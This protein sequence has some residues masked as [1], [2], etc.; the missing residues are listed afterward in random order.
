VGGPHDE[1]L[2]FLRCWHWG[3][4]TDPYQQGDTIYCCIIT[5]YNLSYICNKS[6]IPSALLRK[7]LLLQTKCLKI[8]WMIMKV[9]WRLYLTPYV[10][11]LMSLTSTLAHLPLPER[12]RQR[13]TSE[14]LSQ[15]HLALVCLRVLQSKSS[16]WEPVNK[17]DWPWLSTEK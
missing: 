2:L 16:A 10:D 9:G 11:S 12:T 6:A 15:L 4:Y 8:H 5:I 17:D 14:M 13:P 7:P 3:P 1:I